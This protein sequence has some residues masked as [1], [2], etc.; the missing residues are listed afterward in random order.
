MLESIS[1]SEFLYSVTCLV[2]MYYCITIL[3]L[4]RKEILNLFRKGNEQGS[5]KPGFM[6]SQTR[7]P[8]IMGAIQP[9]APVNT[10]QSLTANELQVA[11]IA[12]TDSNTVNDGLLVGIVADLVN[13]I[14]TLVT[15]VTD[16]EE[17]EQLIKQLLLRYPQLTGS[18][19]Q[20]AITEFIIASCRDQHRWKLDTTTV[21]SWWP[22]LN[23]D[24]PSK[25]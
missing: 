1:W 24:N 19:F 14:I 8:E 11:P 9:D 2:V 6:S 17:G 3:L 23:I 13:E 15:A 4:F 10:H 16:R 12:D 21:D 25:A 20:S 7:S 18:R 5:R 22:T